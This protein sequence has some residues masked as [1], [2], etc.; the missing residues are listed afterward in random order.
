VSSNRDD[1]PEWVKEA[2]A[3]RVGM[4]CSNPACNQITSGPHY[5]PTRSVSVGVAAHISGAA[6]RGPRY[7][8]S[9]TTAERR[10]INNGVWLCQNCAKLVDSDTNRFTVN[11]LLEWKTAAEQK[12]FI[13][14]VGKDFDRHYPSSPAAVHS[15]I[16][17]IHGLDYE[18][19]RSLLID[20]GWQPL[21]HHWSHGSDPMMVAG[22]GKYFWN[23]GY[24]EIS[25]SCPTGLANCLFVFTDVYGNR[26]LVGT[27]G[28]ALP[29]V[30]ATARVWGWHFELETQ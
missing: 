29:E 3:K 14:I 17:K 11:L 28:E 30:G 15:P 7:D 13:E 4:R 16:P 10:S 8:P 26:L 12:A 1:F 5:D 6:S 2:L 9:L 18:I 21:M 25:H 19:A 22:N 24:W 27:A 20:S 23:K